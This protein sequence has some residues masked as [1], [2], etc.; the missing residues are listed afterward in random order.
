MKTIADELKLE[1]Q[2]QPFLEEALKRGIIN[3]SALARELKP[4]LEKALFK[5][6]SES[7]VMMALKRLVPELCSTVP[8]FSPVL[9]K[10]SNLSVRSD[11]VEF[12]FEK[13]KT[14][15]KRIGTLLQK[16]RKD[17]VN[18]FTFTHGTHEITMIV[19]ES[20][21][22]EVEAIFKGEVLVSKLVNLAAISVNLPEES[23]V[24][25]GIHYSIL[26]QLSWNKI[27]IV[28]VVST[29]TEFIIIL[30]LKNV[31]NAFSILLQYLTM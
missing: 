13:S 16:T 22:A 29:Y 30:E 17:P 20:L 3:Y 14:T 18:Y 4:K 25:P 23:V 7:A 26:K 12:T 6:L 8:A 28:E 10:M 2:K 1:I 5:D 11:L 9:K 15:L 31:D 24:T 21:E 27:N 19:S